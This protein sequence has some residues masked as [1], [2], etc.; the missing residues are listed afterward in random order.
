MP[1]KRTTESGRRHAFVSF[2]ERVDSI[3]IEP[4]KRLDKRVHDEVESSHLLTTLEHWNELNLS[5]TFTELSSSIENYCQSLPQVLH[6]KQEIYDSIYQA[7]HKNDIHSLQPSLELLSQFIHDLGP[8]FLPF[9]EKTLQLLVDVVLM[10]SPNDIQNNRNT[11][12]A[13][14][15]IFTTLAFAFKYLVK[16]LTQ[17][18]QPTFSGLLPLLT[19]HNRAYISRFC[20]EALSY[21][22]RKSSADVLRKFIHYAIYEHMEEV[23]SNYHYLESLKVL[24][25]E[26]M[27]STRGSFHTKS[28]TILT[29]LME[30]IV[31]EIKEEY[32]PQVTSLV[33]DI[34]LD[35][36]HHGEQDACQD[37]YK[38]V[39]GAVHD[40]IQTT[41]D[42]LTL[43]MSSQLLSTLCFVDSGRKV[44][45]WSCVLDVVDEILVATKNLQKSSLELNESL[46]YLMT[47]IFRNVD[48]QTLMSR[49]K[50]YFDAMY[51]LNHGLCFLPFAYAGLAIA[52]EKM[53]NFGIFKQIQVYINNSNT[54]EKL[55]SVVLF[56]E[57]QGV[58]GQSNFTIP[59]HIL[60]TQ[61]QHIVQDLESANYQNIYWRLLV[62][63]HTA[64]RTLDESILIQLVNRAPDSVV[65]REVVSLAVELLAPQLEKSSS[66]AQE[67]TLLILDQFEKFS[68]SLNFLPAMTQFIKVVDVPQKFMDSALECLL[69]PSHDTRSH[70]IDLIESILTIEQQPISPIFS[71]IKL[72]EQI[73]LTIDTG[74][75]IMLRVRSLGI[76]LSKEINPTKFDKTAT[77]NFLFGLLSNKFQPSWK[78]VLEAV[79]LIAS[80]CKSEIWKNSFEFLVME[81]ESRDEL[82]EFSSEVA[83]NL[84][85]W[86]PKNYRLHQNFEQ[87]ENNYLVYF[88]NIDRSIDGLA[89]SAYQQ[90]EFETLI[91]SNTLQALQS[92]PFV[93][94]APK[95]AGF[96]LDDKQHLVY[97]KWSKNDK[98]EY[99]ALLSKVKG[100]KK[101]TDS[102]NVFNF[103]LDLLTSTYTKVQQLSLDVIFSFND[104]TINK[105]RDVLKN[106]L[107]DVTFSDELSK[108]TSVD[109]PIESED[110]EHIMPLVIRILF[111]KFQGK[112]ASKSKQGGK[113]AVLLSLPSFDDNE[114][115]SF[116]DIGASKINYRDY[117]EKRMPTVSLGLDNSEL[118]KITG[119][120]NLLQQVYE[121]FR[122]NH[123]SVL[124]TTIEPLIYSLLCAQNRVDCG[125]DGEDPVSDKMARNI[126]SSGMRSLKELFQILGPQFDW[127]PYVGVV[128]NDLIAP[129]LPKFAN[130]N[131]QQPS[132]VL[133]LMCFWIQ[134]PNT[135][136]FLFANDFDAVKAIL[137][138]LEKSD[139]KESVISIV[140]DFAVTALEKRSDSEE[141]YFT[142]LAIVVDSLLHTLS[143]T[144]NRIL[145]PEVGSKAI[146][147]LLLMIQGD[148]IDTKETKSA[149]IQSLTFALERNNQQIDVSDK[150]NILV[151]LSSLMASYDCTF[152]EILPLYHA[153]SK[154]LRVISTKEVRETLATLFGVLGTKFEQLSVVARVIIGLNAYTSRMNEYDFEKRL[155]AYRLVNEELFLEFDPT[156]WMPLIS[157]A[158]FN[159]NDPTELAIRV[160]AGY[161]LKR[162]VDC[163]TSKSSIDEALPYIHL[164]KD[165]ILPIVRIGIRKDNEDVQNEYIAVL[166]YIV[167]NDKY[168]PDLKDLQVLIGDEDEEESQFFRNINHI[169]LHLRQ[170]SIRRLSTFADSL[171]GSNVSHYLLPLLEKY[172]ISKEE[173][174][175]NIGL[176]ALESIKILIRSINWNQF[177]AILKRYLA[178]LK[179]DSEVLRQRVNLVVAISSV[180]KDHKDNG[181]LASNLASQEDIDG[182]LQIDVLPQITKILQVRDD[183]T[184][185]ARA[186]LAEAAI[187]LILS[188]SDDKIEGALPSVLTSLCQVM[189]S[190]SE[191]LR[192]AVRK[193]LGKITI[194][195]GANYFS[196]IVKELKTALSR[197]SQI[198]VLS[199]TVHYLLQCLANV[200]KHGDLNESISLTIEIAMEDIFGAA[201][202]E[203]DADGYTSKMKEVKFKKS[204][205]TC[206]ILASNISLNHF[207]ELINPI[208]LLLQE[209]INHKV[210]VQLDEVLR[211]LSLGLNH[212]IE[213]SN[214]SILHL[215]Y[216]I[217]I[218]SGEADPNQKVTK[219][220]ESE[221][222][223]LTTL[224]RKAKSHVDRSIYK[225]TMQKLS[226]ELLRTA[227]SRHENLLLTSNLRGFVPLLATGVNSEGE[228]VV[229]ASLRVLTIIIRLPFDEEVQGVLKS[230]VRKALLLIKDSPTTN[231]DVCQAALK[232]LATTIKH[233]P[234]VVLKD[235][236]I[237][238]VLTRIQPDLEEPNRQGLAFQFL[239]AIVAQHLLLPEIYD[240]MDSVAKLMIVNH[241]KEIRDMSRSIYFQFLMEY[242]QGKGKLEKSFKFLVNNLTYPTEEGRQ[243]VME[244]IHL[245]ILKA[246]PELLE[247]LASSFFIALA[248]ILV[249]DDSSRSREMANVLL[250]SMMKKLNSVDFIEK[251]CTA[252]LQ[253]SSNVLLKRCG[254]QVYKMLI[255][256]FGM[257]QFPSLNKLVLEN[258][259]KILSDSKFSEEGNSV[260]WELTYSSLSVFGAIVS[261]VKDQIYEQKYVSLW[262]LVIDCLLYPHSW[263][264]L[265]TC[266]LVSV[267]LSNLDKSKL[268]ND[269][270]ELIATKLIHQLRTPSL[271]DELGTLCIKNLAFIA[272]KWEEASAELKNGDDGE[273][274][275]ANDF[276]IKRVCGIIK[277]ENQSTIAKKMTIKFLIL[278]IQL[279]KEDRMIEVSEK[280]IDSLYNFTDEEYCRSLSDDELTNMSLQALNMV[281][282]K[283]GT[284]EYTRLFAKVRQQVDTRRKSRKA[285]RSQMAVTA[286]DIAAKRKFKKHERVR[287]KR[288]HEKDENGYYR[289]KKKRVR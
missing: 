144:I 269:K 181:T 98:N 76:E 62:V 111:G 68:R 247:K 242:D 26:S 159:I 65:G 259:S 231:S 249:S 189:R 136:P 134:S 177:K 148:Y 135:L 263:I 243:S 260:D 210:Q 115:A 10:Q 211:K 197:G 42:D 105:H 119:F 201:G 2:R 205:D 51:D 32:Q 141:S 183:D 155:D 143:S 4:N 130:E 157:N 195:L 280:I 126:R 100:L 206:E 84:I 235:S 104:P 265:I 78:A 236:A 97:Q 193:T 229:L 74:R 139:A 218:M 89:Q 120:I 220:S 282:E 146:K 33:S 274:Q 188:L 164:L 272:V 204:F 251:Y 264:R 124:A 114:I 35:V 187:N 41:Q 85:Q 178:G 40:I 1:K 53:K 145:D 258:I 122:K 241:S 223:F 163:Y 7:I 127:A 275:Y 179:M 254:F 94:D 55:Q 239:K 72:I 16:T 99:L 46:V 244:L 29:I 25:S 262:D 18:L 150:S 256:V 66:I 31:S 240:V 118:K 75:D 113:N 170:K 219:I 121:V 194:A 287:E 21:L 216:E 257:K 116:I 102:E 279:T 19:L 215:C 278:F 267:L 49:H 160:N 140:L 133:L 276:L 47:I 13:L 176:E 3:K 226:L 153:C 17:D 208:K 117:F 93:V 71:Q 166:E 285:K 174:Y 86:Q 207:G 142:L 54:V 283:I 112:P 212:N 224:N 64:R 175:R 209:T 125:V 129:R 11:S 172:A 101:I 156:Q 182:F 56:L 8:D 227:I 161:L 198:H 37:F 162:F 270:M 277:Q 169:Q 253:Q 266:R 110:K 284:T 184:I 79:P 92:A 185:V 59:D 173:K 106:L 82:H 199:F 103:M 109:C 245:I 80:T 261:C 90:N 108:F 196:F 95:L 61:S 63:K 39:S 248:N 57:K 107:D 69:L 38:L 44:T 81:Y 190:R 191:E 154:L 128:S 149:L 192:D 131:L 137:S 52:G 186:P 43:L 6:H 5:G 288:K 132:A 30:C 45:D 9:Y 83:S 232:F 246:G 15:W 87:F 12:N 221:Q 271:S 217:F 14:N 237:S 171:N 289:P 158:L 200:L 213:A 225:Q 286:P 138:L 60:D 152:E 165:T 268:D 28:K 22:V 48:I 222:H 273:M 58:Q 252:W 70:A 147:T 281:K 123:A 180:L 20:A 77:V 67:L 202:Q 91:R 151:A 88:R 233:N 96:L 50:R 168:Y 255:S 214:Q 27:K 73:P 234:K 167:K 250:T 230:C 203:K 36:L 238:Y 24:F 34:L 228:G 23:A